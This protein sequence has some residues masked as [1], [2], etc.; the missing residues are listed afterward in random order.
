MSHRRLLWQLFPS[1]L[2]ITLSSLILIILYSYY[3]IGEIYLQV[4]IGDLESRIQLIEPQITPRLLVNQYAAIDSICKDLGKRSQTRF[5]VILPDGRVLADS[6]RNPSTMD[7]HGD[8]PEVINVLEKGSGS[9]VRY[10]RTIQTEFIYVAEQIKSGSEVRGILRASVPFT[11]LGQTLQAFKKRF[12]IAGLVI[13]CI[14]AIVSM[15]VSRNI[16]RPLERMLEGIERF[17]IGDLSFRLSRAGSL[18]MVRLTDALNQMAGQIDEKIRT[19]IQG[20]NE[21]QAVLEGM[22]EGVVALDADKKIININRAAARLFGLESNSVIGR[23]FVEV[24]LNEELQAVIQK[25]YS[26]HAPVESEI[27]I[28]HDDGY[29]LQV[30]SSLIR[31]DGGDFSGAVMVLNDVTRL[32]RLEKVRQ[33]FVANVSHEIRTP[34]TS[35]KGFAETLLNG[36]I[37]EPETAR[38]FVQIISNQS[39]RLNAI[40]EDLLILARLEHDDD[41]PQLKFKSYSVKKVV[42]DAV[43]LC[44]PKAGDKGINL[45]LDTGPDSK[46]NM[47]PDLM[48]QALVNLIDNAIKYSPENS[49]VTIRTESSSELLTISVTDQ[50]QGIH[51]KHLARLFER[52]YRVDKARSRNLGGTGLGLAIVKHIAHVHGGDVDVVSSP[53]SGSTFFIRIPVKKYD[54]T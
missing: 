34:L 40:I 44:L 23:K 4:K 35:I 41:R 2:T 15:I 18:E 13:T 9:S 26:S 31:D 6:D 25:T 12:V 1:F 50:G 14:I 43:R 20:K 19:I 48:E 54:K 51:Q 46:I 42:Q 21:Q 8:R 32:R 27:L 30:H 22:V 52:F 28:R 37:D 17:T 16:S 49:K 53:G 3:I 45:H 7:N 5:T 39:N 33:D 10:S 29:H 47:N 11:F 38:G 24:I 36:A